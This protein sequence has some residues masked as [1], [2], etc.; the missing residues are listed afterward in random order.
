[1]IRRFG[2]VTFGLGGASYLYQRLT[3]PQLKISER[4]AVRQLNSPRLLT[5]QDLSK[6]AIFGGLRRRAHDLSRNVENAAALSDSEKKNRALRGLVD[7]ARKL[8]E[9]CHERATAFESEVEKK[10]AFKQV[11]DVQ[12]VDLEIRDVYIRALGH[13][14]RG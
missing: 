10:P 13:L 11:I 7:E 4:R 2:C 9:E 6:V 8:T 3:A 1:M 14:K 12:K 5:D